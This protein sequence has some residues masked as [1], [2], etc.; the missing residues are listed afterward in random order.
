MRFNQSVGLSLGL[1]WYLVLLL[2]EA[3]EDLADSLT[4][5]ASGVIMGRRG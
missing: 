2:I 5:I 4:L 1:G 3:E